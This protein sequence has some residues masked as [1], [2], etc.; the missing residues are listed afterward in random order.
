[1]SVI[2]KIDMFANKMDFVIQY[3]DNFPLAKQIRLPFPI[4]RNRSSHCFDLTWMYGD[5]TKL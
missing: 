5:P 1:M 3:C 2:I 4:S